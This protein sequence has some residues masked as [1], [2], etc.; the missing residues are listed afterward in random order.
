V[1]TGAPTTI[2]TSVVPTGTPTVPNATNST[3]P[4][5]IDTLPLFGDRQSNDRKPNTPVGLT[6][7]QFTFDSPVKI[8]SESET[9]Y[10]KLLHKDDDCVVLNIFRGNST[11]VFQELT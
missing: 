4:R 10:L 5:I 7:I 8:A 9:K 6:V 11:K 1:P 3:I 2:P